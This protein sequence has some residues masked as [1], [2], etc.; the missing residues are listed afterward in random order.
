MTFTILIAPTM[1]QRYHLT[2]IL[3]GLVCVSAPAQYFSIDAGTDGFN[4]HVSNGFSPFVVPV[5]VAPQPTVVVPMLPGYEAP[6][7]VRHHK[8]A[9]RSRR[10]NEPTAIP[11]PVMVYYD[12]DDDFYDDYMEDFYKAQ[13]KA[14]KKARKHYKKQFKHH[15]H[16]KHHHH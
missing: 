15:K 6:R 16:H 13:R 14:I 2:A 5:P 10:Y 1:K 12:D 11:V 9:H 8:K 7:Y 4:I 3:I